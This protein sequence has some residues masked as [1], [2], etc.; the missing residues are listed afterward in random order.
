MKCQI[1]NNSVLPLLN[2]NSLSLSSRQTISVLRDIMAA[3][4]I[5]NFLCFYEI[6]SYTQFSVRLS[7]VQI[8]DQINP[9]K[10]I[11]FINYFHSLMY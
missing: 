1:T 5:K 8:V 6:Q 3:W 9:S 2:H 7:T 10:L 11:N 4:P